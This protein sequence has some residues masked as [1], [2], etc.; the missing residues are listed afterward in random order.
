MLMGDFNF[1]ARR[2]TEENAHIDPDYRDMWTALRGDDPGYTEDTDINL[3]RLEK[4]QKHKQVR[5]DRML[6]RSSTPGWRPA[7]IE[8]LGTKSI[9]SKLPNVFPSDHF[10]LRGTLKWI[11]S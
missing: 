6:V 8:L 1:C 5:F 11:E 9:S 3:M 7:S 2:S 4:T 10:G